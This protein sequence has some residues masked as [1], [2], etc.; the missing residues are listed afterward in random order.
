MHAQQ[1]SVRKTDYRKNKKQKG[2]H[3]V[4]VKHN[5]NPRTLTGK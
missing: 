1:A 2:G 5:S 3:M 4:M